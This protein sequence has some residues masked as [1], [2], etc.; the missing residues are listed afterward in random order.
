MVLF[1]LE[2]VMMLVVMSFWVKF[3]GRSFGKVVIRLKLL[4]VCFLVV[5]KV[6]MVLS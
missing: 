4:L 1:R 3:L 6:L 5:I 2:K